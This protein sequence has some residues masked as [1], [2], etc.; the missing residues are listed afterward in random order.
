MN[1]QGNGQ[2]N[3]G[4]SFTDNGPAVPVAPPV[5]STSPFQAPPAPVNSAPTPVTP[6]QKNNRTVIV[7]VVVAVIVFVLVVLGILASIV[8]V[9]LSSAKNKA[10]DAAVK[11]T[12]SATMTGAIVYQDSNGTLQ[13]FKPEFGMQFKECTGTP[14]V[15]VS[16]NKKE[17]AILVKSCAEQGKYFCDD[18]NGE[19]VE[20]D[21]AMAQSGVY[22][23]GVDS[24]QSSDQATVDN[25]FQDEQLGYSIR[26]P[27][28]WIM[29]NKESAVYFSPDTE[30][31]DAI[32]VID[33]A[34]NDKLIAQDQ[35]KPL[36]N[37][38]GKILAAKDGKIY[39]EKEFIYKFEDG[40]T[41]VGRHLKV[42]YTD[43]GVRVK[44]W[45][46]AVPNGS[47]VILFNYTAA[48]DH[49]DSNYQSV[50]AMLDS[51]KIDK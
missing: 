13:G 18:F 39:D 49:Y 43:N 25:A 32:V 15:N 2:M 46:I 9:S 45:A 48:V 24:G 34:K 17:M 42:E 50:L 5:A 6:D 14:V 19:I 20:V 4:I 23:C 12:I 41:T 31:P 29:E 33:G 27:S 8:L 40:T 3:G 37:K 44:T 7:V 22:N 35:V 10:Q 38:F 26:Y 28:D 11:A 30:T 36:L 51:W 21:E 1:Q 47:K 16:P